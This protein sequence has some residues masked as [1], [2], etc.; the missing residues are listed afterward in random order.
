MGSGWGTPLGPGGEPEVKTG[1]GQPIARRH[2]PAAAGDRN[3]GTALSLMSVSMGLRPRAAG[4]PAPRGSH[5]CGCQLS[6]CTPDT[7]PQR[8][9][10]LVDS[11][12]SL[13]SWPARSR[14][15]C[16]R[17]AP[18]PP[19]PRFQVC[20]VAGPRD[21]GGSSDHR[22][23][24]LRP[25]PCTSWDPHWPSG[26]GSVLCVWAGQDFCE[27]SVRGSLVTPTHPPNPRGSA[28]GVSARVP[29]AVTVRAGTGTRV[30]ELAEDRE[31]AGHPHPVQGPC[32]PPTFASV[33][34]GPLSP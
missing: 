4:P 11:P 22:L 3:L 29:G 10:F 9:D 2:A 25:S 24:S 14:A 5:R 7:P 28:G 23:C 13:T 8:L 16:S 6:H 31:R 12:V 26:H 33:R 19:G 34:A 1:S 30:P 20:G 15:Q 21:G 17:S 27:G 18:Q 32:V